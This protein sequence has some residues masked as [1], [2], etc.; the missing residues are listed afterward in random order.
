MSEIDLD[1][2]ATETE[3]STSKSS[4]QLL[5]P[6]EIR[7]AAA[8]LQRLLDGLGTALLGQRVLLETVVICLLARGNLLLEGL[9]GLG[10]PNS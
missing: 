3:P 1:T 10:K 5:S 2:S 9:P 4:G 6:E 8:H 7:E